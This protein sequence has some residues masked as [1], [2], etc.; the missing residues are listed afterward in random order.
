MMYFMSVGFPRDYSIT[1]DTDPFKHV[2]I[3][4]QGNIGS[5][6]GNEVWSYRDMFHVMV[7]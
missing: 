2:I 4:K 7:F 6:L 1:T 3:K 5:A